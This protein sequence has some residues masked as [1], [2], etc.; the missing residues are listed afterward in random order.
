MQ[1]QKKS[2]I[3]TNIMKKPIKKTAKK[4][5]KKSVK[6][7]LGKQIKSVKELFKLENKK[8][9]IYNKKTGTTIPASFYLHMYFI[10]VCKLIDLGY[11][12]IKK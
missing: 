4:V 1:L 9:S 10:N 8:K 2:K 6:P 3:K 12:F 7:E 11:L 5:N